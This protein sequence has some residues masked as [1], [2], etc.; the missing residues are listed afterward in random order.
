VNFFYLIILNFLHTE[1]ER[2]KKTMKKAN[3]LKVGH[4]NEQQGE[5]VSK[6]A[7]SEMTQ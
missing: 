5:Q 6:R 3:D 2:E 1:S 7:L 4:G